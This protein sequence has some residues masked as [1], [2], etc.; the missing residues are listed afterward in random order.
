MR[1]CYLIA[2]AGAVLAPLAAEEIKL[3]RDG[4]FWVQTITGSDAA[5]PHGRLRVSTQGPVTLR[6]GADNQ[7]QYTVTRR[8]KAR[9]EA[10]ARRLLRDLLVKAYRQ[11]DMHVIAVA[12]GGENRSAEL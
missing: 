8:V 2:L 5:A 12:A 9:D 11:G 6:G 3:T 7:L 1:F 4:A 10:E